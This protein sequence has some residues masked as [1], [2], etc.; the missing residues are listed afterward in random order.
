MKLSFREVSSEKHIQSQLRGN[1]KVLKDFPTAWLILLNR[2]F[3]P[4]IKSGYA[5]DFL[6]KVRTSL[7]TCKNALSEHNNREFKQ[8]K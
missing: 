8:Q 1:M 7:G 3:S 4:T 2:E 5:S 6:K